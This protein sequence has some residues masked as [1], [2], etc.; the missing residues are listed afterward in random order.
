MT[1]TERHLTFVDGKIVVKFTRSERKNKK[2]LDKPT[3]APLVPYIHRYLDRAP[4]NPAA[5]ERERTRFGST[6]TATR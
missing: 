4:P 5:R 3:P 2:R 6:S 1:A